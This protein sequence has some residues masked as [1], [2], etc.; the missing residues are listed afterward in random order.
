MPGAATRLETDVVY[1]VPPGLLELIAR[2]RHEPCH[3]VPAHQ[4]WGRTLLA[5]RETV[6]SCIAEGLHAAFPGREV[7]R[8][9]GAE[10]C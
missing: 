5:I 9:A 4:R 1:E 7:Q 6:F 10:R 2:M 3:R 8:P